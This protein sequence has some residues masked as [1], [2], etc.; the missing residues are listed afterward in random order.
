MKLIS[1][2]IMTVALLI[3]CLFPHQNVYAAT[4]INVKINGQTLYFDQ[5]PINE[6]GRVLVPMRTIFEV[7]GADVQWVTQTAT[8]K[9]TKGDL[10][11]N[12]PLNHKQAT[13]NGVKKGLDVPAKSVNGRTLVPLRFVSEALGCQVVWKSAKSLVSIS[14]DG[15]IVIPS[16]AATPIN[17]DEEERLSVPIGNAFDGIEVPLL[18]SEVFDDFL[19]K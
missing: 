15:E 5:P 17:G 18:K 3:T 16:P 11:I 9:A 10:M 6:N 4:S 2:I 1:I 7:M 8:V 12:L 14:Y 13:I 19:D